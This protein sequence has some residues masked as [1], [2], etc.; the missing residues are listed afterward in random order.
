[1]RSRILI[2]A[3]LFLLC[4]PWGVAKNAPTSKVAAEQRVDSLLEK[5][6]LEE[7]ITIFGGIN[8]FYTQ[9]ISRL[10]IPSL[11]MSDGPLGVHDYGPT[12]AYPAGI[13]LAASWDMELA[14]RVGTMMGRDARARGVH[15]ILAPGMNIYRAPMNGR[16]FEYFGED[17]FLAARVAVSL[18]KGIQSQRV[19]ATAKHFAGNNS[20]YG[21]MDV[22]SD[23]DERTLREIYLPAFEASV[24]EA[25]VGAI[26]DAY[27]PVN[28]VYMTQNQHLNNEILKKEWG[29]DGILMSDWGATHD[30]VAAANG[31]LDLEMPNAS[32][33]NRDALLPAIK[34]GRVSIAT[35]DDKVRRILRKA[36][37][38]G[39]FDQ[40]QTD[41]GIPQL[42]Q[43]GRQVVVQEARE[44]MVLLKNAGGVLPLDKSRVKTIAVIGPN[45]YPAVIGGGGSSLTKPFNAVSFLEGIS[46]YLGSGVKVLYAPDVPDLAEVFASSESLASPDGSSGLKGEYFNNETLEGKP[47]LVR[48]DPRVDFQWG[49]ASYGANG[50]VD[51]FSVRWTGSFIPKQSGDYSFYTNS[52]DGV[53]LFIDEQQVISDWQRH[54]ETVNS[55]AAH[56]EAGQEYKIRLEYFEA[57]GGATIGFAVSPTGK[58]IGSATKA[59]A[60]N[61]DAVILCVGFEPN[62]ESEGSDRTF[63]LP[64][65]QEALI[66]QISEANKN[67]IVVLTAGGNVA[68]NDWIDNVAGLLHAWYPGQEGGTALAQILFGEY[69]PSGKLPASFER[70]WEDNATNHSYYPQKKEEKRVD[71]S[72]GVFVGYRHFDR[73]T[74]KPRFAFG[75]GLSYTTFAYKNLSISPRAGNLSGPITVSFDLTN[76]GKREGAEVAEVY[77]GDGHAT[78]ARPVKELKGFARVNLKAG[79]SRRVSIQLD[80]RAFSFYDVESKDWKAEAGD[81]LLLVG[82]SSDDIRLQGTF[83]LAK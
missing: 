54:S 6:T 58:W 78:V 20:E 32:F 62:T 21:R 12:T 16:N 40:P 26:M 27:N 29:F 75:Y 19:I 7:K 49:D 42:D 17:P 38:F 4:G 30:G 33:M 80:R 82:N 51:H 76:T 72:E 56:L 44:G 67:T 10:G 70:R 3:I 73:A 36:I 41:T 15:F 18:I 28:G 13:A 37:E 9:A 45:A 71:Y 61:A 77:V 39:F 57:V 68:M 2:L 81:F 64:A 24:K 83:N 74:V 25:K 79:E 50:P 69:S 65:G 48:V 53:R 35:I 55:Y 22:S 31:G 14:G 59:L 23:I 66:H 52:D 5:M 46:N 34:D 1:M 47:A 63:R 11:K 43:E 60:K 8:S